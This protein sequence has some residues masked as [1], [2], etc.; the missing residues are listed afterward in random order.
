MGNCAG[1][2]TCGQRSCPAG[3]T[4]WQVL[5]VRGEGVDDFHGFEANADDL[6]DEADDVFFII[7]VVGVAGDAA[8]FVGADLVLVDD[9]IEGAV[10]AEAVL[11]DRGRDFGE[12]ERV[13][14][15]ELGLV[16][17]EFYFQG[18]G[19]PLRDVA[20]C[21]IVIVLYVTFLHFALTGLPKKYLQIL[22]IQK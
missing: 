8:A 20:H 5:L 6:A 11:E 13:V 3:R 2:F 12:C 17:G 16:F 7:G 9:P 4:Y 18:M 1:S 15:L 19:R 21:S 10:V 22:V 14:H